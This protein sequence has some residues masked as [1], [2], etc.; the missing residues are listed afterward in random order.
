ME[1]RRPLYGPETWASQ[2][3]FVLM[4]VILLVIVPEEEQRI[5][6]TIK[7]TS[8]R[9]P[10]TKTAR[11]DMHSA[12]DVVLPSVYWRQIRTSPLAKQATNKRPS[13]LN[14]RLNKR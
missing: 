2:L 7:S 12:A 6:I 9:Q 11:L 10:A 14:F 1:P 13:A 8:T 3:R 4:I 5:T